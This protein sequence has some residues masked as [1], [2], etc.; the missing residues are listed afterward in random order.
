MS[1]AAPM[2]LPSE[3]TVHRAGKGKAK[4]NHS[5]GQK[6][7]ELQTLIFSAWVAT[8]KDGETGRDHTW[9][10]QLMR[11]ADLLSQMSPSQSS[12]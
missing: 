1:R 11:S 9:P 8:L 10:L 12:D 4:E 3:Q 7:R 2:S 5:L 6:K